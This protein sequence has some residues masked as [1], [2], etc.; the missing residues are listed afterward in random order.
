MY[1]TIAPGTPLYRVTRENE[2]WPNPVLGLGAYFTTG[3]YNGPHQPAVYASDDPL[4]PITEA[5]FY[6]A[7]AWQERIALHHVQPVGYPFRSELRL[8]CFTI[9]PA[10]PVIDLLDPNAQHRFPHPPH[11]L[12]SPANGT[13]GRSSSPTM[14]EPTSHPPGRSTP[15]R[16][17]CGRPPCGRRQ[18]AATSPASSSFL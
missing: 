8:W 12:L 16:K 10:P 4:V 9:D 1:Y 14:S 17:A 13:T 11:L 18:V 3:R 15:A 6:Q 7:L 2:T 5:A